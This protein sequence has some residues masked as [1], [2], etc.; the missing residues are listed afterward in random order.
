MEN[1]H[2]ISDDIRFKKMVGDKSDD[3]DFSMDSSLSC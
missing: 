3:D 1:S 2:E